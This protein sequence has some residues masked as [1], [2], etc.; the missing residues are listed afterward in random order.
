[1]IP[2]AVKAYSR[3][4]HS[5]EY[6]SDD[7]VQDAALAIVRAG[8]ARLTEAA[9]VVVG[10]NA[11]RDQM[12]KLRTRRE[13]GPVLLEIEAR[14]PVPG[15]VALASAQDTREAIEARVGFQA[16]RV[17]SGLVAGHTQAETARRLDIS[18]GATFRAVQSLRKQALSLGV[19]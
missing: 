3:R 1:M 7:L 9:R 5:T 12:R 10:L 8:G 4:M 11:V 2:E 13:R 17:L 14:S 6:P 18:P 16:R 15:P 19:C